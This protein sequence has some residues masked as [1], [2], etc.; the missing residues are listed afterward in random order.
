M[1]K[2]KVMACLIEQDID[3]RSIQVGAHCKR[4]LT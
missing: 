4:N 2:S 3:I 1:K